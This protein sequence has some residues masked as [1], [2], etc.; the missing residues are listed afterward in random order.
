M[1]AASRS[2]LTVARRKHLRKMPALRHAEI[3]HPGVPE[4]TASGSTP[5][6][7][8]SRLLMPD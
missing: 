3:R 1:A 5:A 6:N 2:W 8:S 7:D 4:V